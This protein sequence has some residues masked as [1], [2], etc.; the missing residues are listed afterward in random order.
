MTAENR[1]ER[2]MES[3]GNRRFDVSYYES[4]GEA[5]AGLLE[6]I[7]PGASVGVGGSMTIQQLDLLDELQSRDCPVFWHWLFPP[8][9]RREIL[10]KAA[11]A[12]YY[13]CSANA[14]TE[15][16]QIVNVDGGGN[17]VSSM[18]FGPETVI[19][20]IGKNK[21]VGNLDEALKRIKTVA[22]PL[23]AKRLGLSTP[24]V[25]KGQ[26]EN[27]RTICSVTAIMEARPLQT[28]MEVVIVNSDLG[29]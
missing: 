5:R 18:I 25:E 22:A 29:F 8:E 24:C 1:I 19:I 7:T 15:S 20:V 6:K 13:L 4:A 11:G 2:L 16:G 10:K 23:N 14:V 12:D 28:A 21:I 3:L 27:C 26:C 9:E 17:R